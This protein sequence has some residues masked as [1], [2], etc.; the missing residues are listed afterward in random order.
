MTVPFILHYGK[1][2]GRMKTVNSSLGLLFYLGSLCS[3]STFLLYWY[4]FSIYNVVG[5]KSLAHR[6]VIASTFEVE[7]AASLTAVL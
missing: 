6:C 1:L 5:R 2:G 7:V 3:F 4:I